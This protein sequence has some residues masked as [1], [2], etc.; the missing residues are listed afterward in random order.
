MHQSL[1]KPSNKLKLVDVN[2]GQVHIDETDSKQTKKYKNSIN[3]FKLIE[4]D[5]EQSHIQQDK[6]YRQFIKDIAKNK[7]TNE[8]IQQ[9]SQ[10]VNSHV[11]SQDVGRWY[12]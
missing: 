2:G 11:V 5:G 4:D 8:E 3:K 9:I 1:K 12:A 6:I 10:L 7:L